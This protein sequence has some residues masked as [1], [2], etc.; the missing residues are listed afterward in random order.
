MSNKLKQ[1]FFTK[2]HGAG[3]DYIYVDATTQ[4]VEKA[5]ELSRRLSHRHTGVGADGLVLIESSSVAHYAMRIFNADGSEALMC[6]NALR[7]VG[8][9]L[10]DNDMISSDSVDIETKS[11]VRHLQLLVGENGVK[12]VVV[13]MGEPRLANVLQ[14][15]TANG[16]LD[17]AMVNIEGRDCELTYVCMGNPHVVCFV[18]DVNKVMLYE[19]GPTIECDE[20]FPQRTNVEFAQIIDYT[21]IDMRVWERGSGETQA[22]GS[23]ACA[24]MVAA[25]ATGRCGRKAHVMMPGGSLIIEWNEH[26]NHVYMTGEAVTVFTGVVD[27]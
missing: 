25:C 6:G 21:H 18:D 11:G 16:R 27:V 4:M 8:K 26:D 12:N 22:C 10:F 24:T 15:N 20:V 14:V 13:D 2:M 5:S 3:N 9:F 1:L 17:D 23:G 19:I 7:C